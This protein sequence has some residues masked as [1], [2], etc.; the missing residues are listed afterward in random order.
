MKITSIYYWCF[1]WILFGFCTT[2]TARPK[3]WKLRKVTIQGNQ[4]FKR[5]ELKTLIELK[6]FWIF[7]SK[8]YSDAKL[9]SD[10][11][12]L[13]RFYRSQGF[14]AADIQSSVTADSLRRNVSIDINIEEGVRT[15]I[16]S[17]HL[18]QNRSVLDSS[19]LEKL[20]SK[21]NSPLILPLLDKDAEYLRV[22]LTNKGFLKASVKPDLTVDSVKQNASVTFVVQVGPM[23][24]VDTILLS[25][26]NHVHSKVLRR[27]LAFSKGDT[28]TSKKI[29]TSEQQLYKTNLF[30]FAQI[31]PTLGDA[32]NPEELSL[33]PDS[34]YP[35]RVLVQQADFF[36]I[37]GGVGYGT[38]ENLRASLQTSY[39]NVFQIGH[40]LAFK[41]KYSQKIRSADVIY[42]IPWLFGLPL[43]FNSTVY[44]NQH[45]DYEDTYYGIFRGLRLTAGRTT[46]FNLTYQF[47]MNW[48]E[49]NELE[50]KS[51][52]LL[53]ELPTKSVGA[54]ISYDTRNDLINPSKGIFNSLETE[55]SGIMGN[56]NQFIRIY[57]DFRFYWKSGPV[58]FGTGIKA[59]WVQTYG[60]SKTIPPQERFYTGGA[61]SVRGFSENYLK[62]EASGAAQSSNFMFTANLLDIRYPLFWW[63]QGALFLDAGNVWQYAS[64][65]DLFN[66]LRW[67]AG[68]GL[69]LNTPIAVV[70]FDVGFKLDRK[71]GENRYELHFDLG[72]PF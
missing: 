45:D 31:E 17:I 48:E 61:R 63:F 56:S 40:S 8:K 47:L 66:D 53:P 21:P 6:K 35:V 33:L 18:L 55:I 57:D 5:G 69:R 37:E 28:L 70:R 62:V 24:C 19:I 49:V 68:P 34:S 15:N 59:G 67:S 2:A 60:E 3:E 52:S 39:A 25:G 64:H 14:F 72:Q 22:Q 23:I 11:S 36:R 42:G 20:K 16:S 65:R 26:N 4:T 13:T 32:S 54:T 43:Q 9:R 51:D 29:R 41:G 10:I 27:E 38:D 58:I 71:T 7:S 46:T 44:L 12:S 1:L 30:N 50:A